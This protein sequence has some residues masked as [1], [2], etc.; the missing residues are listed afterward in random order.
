[1]KLIRDRK[2]KTKNLI[3]FLRSVTINEVVGI[4][5]YIENQ[6]VIFH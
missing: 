4:D 1:M 5:F 6:F 2:Q 3:L